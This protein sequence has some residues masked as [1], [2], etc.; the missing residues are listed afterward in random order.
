MTSRTVFHLDCTP[1]IPGCGSECGSCV[2]AMES[3][4]GSDPAATVRRLSSRDE[5]EGVSDPRPGIVRDQWRRL[6]N[7]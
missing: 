3:A 5:E 6:R 2:G 7:G 1:S 4:L